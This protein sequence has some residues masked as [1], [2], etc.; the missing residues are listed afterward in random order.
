MKAA[1]TM[2]KSAKPNKSKSSNGGIKST[3]RKNQASSKTYKL[4]KKANN[5][6]C[7]M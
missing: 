2:K 7:K 3:S 5:S 6:M 4:T 1:N